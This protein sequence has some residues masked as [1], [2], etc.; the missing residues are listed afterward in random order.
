M[1]QDAINVDTGEI[2]VSSEPEILQSVALGSCVAVAVYERTRKI[3]GLAHIM[4][5]GKSPSRKENTR[6]AEDALDALFGSVKSLVARL[7]DLEISVV[8]GANVLRKG[9][10]PDKVIDS[11]LD[12]LRRAN[13]NLQGMRLGGFERRSVFLDIKTGNVFY[14]EGNN[15]TPVLLKDVE[16]L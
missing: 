9:D 12:Y 8:G 5:P 2:K 3:G 13:L 10:I 14:T 1:P 6:Y 11:V 16:R 7:D 4:L 15:S